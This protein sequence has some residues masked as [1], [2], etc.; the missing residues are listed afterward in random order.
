M[1]FLI[2]LAAFVAVA[3]CGSI[4]TE[5]E[6]ANHWQKF[7]AEHGKTYA[8]EV[9]EAHRMKIFKENAIKVAKHNARYEAGEVS[10]F[11]AINK[12]ADMHTHEVAEKLNGYRSPV[13]KPVR[14][15]HNPSETVGWPWPWPSHKSVDWRKKGYV[16][17]IKDQ[18]QC[19]SC[20]AFS[21]VS[22]LTT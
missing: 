22:I 9:E 8:N 17:D 7:K 6:I 19:G 2:V 5:Q 18:G 10:F 12:F 20:W 3:T 13:N 11:V 21:T 15:I 14:E 4:P 16:T 1:K